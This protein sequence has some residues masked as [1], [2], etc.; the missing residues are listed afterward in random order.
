MAPRPNPFYSAPAAMQAWLDFGNNFFD[1]GLEESLM[2]LVR[3]RATQINGWNRT[4][5]G[6]CVV[7]PVQQREAA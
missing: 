6:I 5:V 1:S 7:S 2:E 3:I 4:Q